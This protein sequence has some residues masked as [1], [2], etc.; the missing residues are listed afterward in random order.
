MKILKVREKRR[1]VKVKELER[2]EGLFRREGL[3][4]RKRDGSFRKDGVSNYD[5]DGLLLSRESSGRKDGV[6]REG[7]SL[8]RYGSREK[9]ERISLREYRKYGVEVSV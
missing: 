5:G 3:E 9:R 6:I 2:R 1:V 8:R 4:R 7:L